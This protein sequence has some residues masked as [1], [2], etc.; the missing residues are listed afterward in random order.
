MWSVVAGRK[1]RDLWE[2]SP[3]SEEVV[4]WSSERPS[5]RRA[6]TAVPS[7]TGSKC[8]SG[9]VGPRRSPRSRRARQAPCFNGP[10]AVSVASRLFRF[11]RAVGEHLREI[12]RPRQATARAGGQKRGSQSAFGDYAEVVRIVRNL[13]HPAQYAAD[14][15]RSR[16]T[17]KYLQWQF[18]VV[19]L[20]R[21]WLAER[22]N[23]SLREHMRAGGSALTHGA[24]TAKSTSSV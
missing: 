20:C 2:T 6:R 9:R 1:S 11:R 12:G 19:L 5:H 18:E 14:H 17:A 7:T 22:N 10:K 3:C 8:A 24:F 15:H 23:K 13:G 16:V 21:D 4:A